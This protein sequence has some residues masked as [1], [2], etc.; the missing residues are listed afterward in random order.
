MDN[1]IQLAAQ[2]MFLFAMELGVSCKTCGTSHNLKMV[3]L[4]QGES[5]T[6]FKI[7]CRK[8]GNELTEINVSIR[9]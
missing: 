6:N 8:S 4:V 3:R 7:T 2:E 1:T 9:E 5:E